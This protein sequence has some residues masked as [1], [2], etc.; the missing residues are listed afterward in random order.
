[1]RRVSYATTV[2]PPKNEQGSAEKVKA[3]IFHTPSRLSLPTVRATPS[4][5]PYSRSGV[6]RPL[7]S[8]DTSV[9]ATAHCFPNRVAH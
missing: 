5:S 4:S 1:M 6:Q 9:L 2:Y 8:V 3:R 7:D